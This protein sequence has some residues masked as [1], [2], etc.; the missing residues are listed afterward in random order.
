[1]NL[2]GHYGVV[3]QL[4]TNCS[5]AF[6]DTIMAMVGLSMVKNSLDIDWKDFR[7]FAPWIATIA[8]TFFLSNVAWGIALGVVAYTLIQ[9][10]GAPAA[11]MKKL[12]SLRGVGAPVYVL[13]LISVLLVI[14]AAM[15]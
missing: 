3:L 8:G 14:L 1:M 2:Y 10:V 7:G 6:A 13:T 5:F 12:E 9:V 4:L 15:L 11:G